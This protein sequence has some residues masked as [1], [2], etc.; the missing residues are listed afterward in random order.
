[1]GVL[2]SMMGCG[3]MRFDVTWVVLALC[4]VL[5]CHIY[6][7]LSSVLL[8]C[9]M[10]CYV[11]LCCVVLCYVVHVCFNAILDPYGYVM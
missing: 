10:F 2:C 4:C 3:V 1:M 6:I 7:M 11:M 9:V 8:R 5:F